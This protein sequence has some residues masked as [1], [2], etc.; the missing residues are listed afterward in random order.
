MRCPK[1]GYVRTPEDF[2]PEWQCP[3]CQVAYAKAAARTDY[4]DQMPP[5][6]ARA[7]SSPS[8][9][10]SF[11]IGKAIFVVALLAGLVYFVYPFVSGITITTSKSGG[12]VGASPIVAPDNTVLLYSSSG[13]PYCKKA[14]DFLSE[15]NIAYEDIDVYQS[16]RG[17]EDFRKLGAIGVPIFVVGDTKLIGYE[18]D[19]LEDLLKSKGLWK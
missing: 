3:S 8:S 10:P 7:V 15:H 12:L 2:A 11:P 6:A 14:R 9:G 5:Q 17:R 13:C 4:P 18:K 1:C 16:E 19:Q